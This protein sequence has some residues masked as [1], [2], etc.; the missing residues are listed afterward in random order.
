MYVLI[1]TLNAV[2][3]IAFKAVATVTITIKVN[4]CRLNLKCALDF[5]NVGIC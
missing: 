4:F 1:K 5:G 3:P 2:A